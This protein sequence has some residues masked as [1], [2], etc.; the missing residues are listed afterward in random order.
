MLQI[1]PCIVMCGLIDYMYAVIHP[2]VDERKSAM[3]DYE[4]YNKALKMG[5]RAYREAKGK[6][7]YPYLPALDE[8]LPAS[9]IQTETPMGLM[10]IPLDQIVG[11]KTAGRQQAFAA[12]FMPLMPPKS[13]FAMKWV[14]LYDYQ[15]EEGVNDP[16][17]CY[18]YMN[19]YYVLEGNKRVS[20]FKYLNAYSIEGSVTRIVPRLTSDP[21][22][23]ISYEYMEFYRKTG[24]NYIYFTKEGSFAALTR[25]TGHTEEAVWTDEEKADFS[26][27]Y[28]RFQKIFY[29][30]GGKKLSI[31]PGDAFVFYLSLYSYSEFAEKTEARIKS[32]L[33]KIWKE[34]AVIEE[35]PGKSYVMDPRET[36]EAGMF[37]RF[38]A[39]TGSSQLKVA[40]VHD[41]P[42]DMSSWVYGHELGRSYLDN[43]FKDKIET[44]SYFMEPDA[45]NRIGVIESAIED[46]NHIIFT[47]SG[48][49]QEASLKC[50]LAHPE[51]KILNCSVNRPY[52]ALR[53]YYGRLFEV[54]YLEGVI[55]GAMT[56]NNR[57]A[58]VADFPLY[59]SIANINAFALGV[60]MTN[61]R[62]GV[63]LSWSGKKEH[64]LDA[65]I[66]REDIHVIADMDT[67][68]PGTPNRRYG[69]YALKE[70]RIDNLAST[71]WDWGKFYERI[72]RDILSGSWNAQAKEKKAMHYLWGI[73][74]NIVDLLVSQSL[75]AGIARL[76]KILRD[77]I[78]RNELRPFDT[79]VRDQSHQVINPDG[80]GL[81]IDEI[82]KM[83][84]LC[85]N[86]IGDIP[87]LEE[88]TESGQSL[89]RLQ[90]ADGTIEEL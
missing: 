87:A 44:S 30:L 63:Y 50:A 36:P 82:L 43:I 84:W 54:K 49:L 85:E 72:I 19:K 18:E 23:R 38:F 32:E 3:A 40:F 79:V 86:V 73:S 81:S 65:L 27:V 71:I 15:L 45:K 55:A 2:F 41:R 29:D 76:V 11:T 4:D 75:P 24:I 42:L 39:G 21:Q 10:D 7:K 34:Y 59:G 64:D 56:D 60:Q 17:V 69:L 58:Y 1:S 83:N 6:G 62:A 88:L 16:I 77:E 80:N 90:S 25:L 47:T 57:I 8:F 12:N 51:V 52:Q 46:G 22:V 31:T 89:V 48:R 68:R 53:T 14:H 61:P 20:V 28:L 33:E 74:G 37:T 35:A 26:S 66:Q 78:S 9:E 70:D 13:E 67:I 5:Q